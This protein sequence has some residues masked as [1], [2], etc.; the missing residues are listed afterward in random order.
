M[1][2]SLTQ[3]TSLCSAH[4][5]SFQLHRNKNH[6]TSSQFILHISL[7]ALLL[8]GAFVSTDFQ[9]EWYVLRCFATR[10]NYAFVTFFNLARVLVHT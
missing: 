2:L 10:D 1:P 6:K 5:W 9:L 3:S 4:N 7:Q 8:Y